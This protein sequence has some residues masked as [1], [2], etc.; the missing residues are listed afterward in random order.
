MRNNR[1]KEVGIQYSDNQITVTTLYTGIENLNNIVKAVKTIDRTN[2][3]IVLRAK[4]AKIYKYIRFRPIVF[5]SVR[6]FF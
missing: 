6:G 5:V 1:L 2:K 3:T 4:L